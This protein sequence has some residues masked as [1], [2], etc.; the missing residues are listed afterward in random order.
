MP[1]LAGALLLL[2]GLLAGACDLV[3][4][5]SGDVSLSG[6][7]RTEGAL[8]DSTLFLLRVGPEAAL[9]PPGADQRLAPGSLSRS[10]P[11]RSPEA[12]DQPSGSATSGSPSQAASPYGCVMSTPNLTSEA[13]YRYESVYAFFP[14][15]IEDAGEETRKVTFQMNSRTA[16]AT[17][18]RPVA[19]VLRR[20][21]C[22]IPDTD[23]AERLVR[24]RLEQFPSSA[25]AQQGK[26]QA[27][28]GDQAKG[29]STWSGVPVSSS[30]DYLS[31]PS[32]PASKDWEC[33]N[34]TLTLAYCVEWKGD[35]TCYYKESCNAYEWN[36]ESQSGSCDHLLVDCGDDP[37][38][39]TADGSA[40]DQ[41]CESGGGP[42]ALPDTIIRI[43]SGERCSDDPLK[44]M[45]IRATG[46]AAEG[47]RNVDGGRFGDTRDGG[48]THHDGIDLLND[49]GDP[50]EA[51]EG[52]L[53][54]SVARD[55]G[56]YGYYV[57]IRTDGPNGEYEYHWY[58]H[59]KEENRINEL[60]ENGDPVTVDAGEE[61]GQTGTSG[62]ASADSC[63]SGGPSHLHYEIR[64]GSSFD[65]A[66][67]VNPENHLGTQFNDTGVPISDTC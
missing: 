47:D 36:E 46:C 41:L 29:I 24:E 61:I 14:E 6:D 26:T 63:D 11:S 39:C 3:T 19:H 42:V 17:S 43:R 25:T 23:E 18:P 50:V 59:L 4:G 40:T 60:D 21:T 62:S 67:P 13:S 54:L 55:K 10:Q 12:E 53:V 45:E 30:I 48:D 37:S 66:D 33:T 28:S 32:G 16:Y 34:Y 64:Q 1:V 38:G 2:T 15:Y 57:I 8:P 49:V 56:G 9:L 58:T 27:D 5:S 7:Q 22:R 65:E 35:I 31:S 44:D 51:A 20:A 52:G